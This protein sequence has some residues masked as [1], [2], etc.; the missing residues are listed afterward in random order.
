MQNII[1][2]GGIVMLFFATNTSGGK[3]QA[4]KK[5]SKSLLLLLAIITLMVNHLYLQ[6]QWFNLIIDVNFVFLVFKT[7]PEFSDIYPN[8]I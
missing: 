7:S 4:T 2:R 6:M 1:G 3:S 5:N 8:T